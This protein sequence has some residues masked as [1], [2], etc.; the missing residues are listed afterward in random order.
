MSAYTT[1]NP[2]TQPKF[3]I[4]SLSLGTNTHHDIP[5]KVRVTSNLGYDGI[6]IF[7]PDFEAFVDEVKRGKH[8]ELFT[9]PISSCS[10]I[11]LDLAC[12]T[13][14]S[15]LCNSFGL[16]IPLFQPLRNFE[17]F[18]SQKEI[19]VGLAEAER[20]LR[21]M[22][23]MKCDLLLVCSNHLPGPCPISEDYTVDMYNDKQVNAFRQLGALAENYGVRIGY[24]PLS[25]GTV[26]DNWMQVW[27]I[28]KRVDR[29]NVGILL[30]SFN[31]LGNQYADP[32][33]ASTIRRGQ[34]LAAMLSNLEEMT[35]TI[36][37]EKIFF[38]QIADA[39]RPAGICL[40][41]INMPRRMKWSRACRVF[42]CE[43]PDS[44]S[45]KET[46]S[47]PENPPSGYLGFLPVTQ[48]TSL[49]HRMGYRGWWSLEVFNSSLQESDN[50]CP[51]RHGR[52]GI[53]GLHALWDVVQT[54]TDDKLSRDLE[55]FFDT[56]RR[57]TP[58]P[59][60]LTPPLS[61]G[62]ISDASELSSPLSDSEFE[63]EL[64]EALHRVAICDRS[65]D[66]N[67]GVDEL[68]VKHD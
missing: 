25:W 47:H 50:G 44:S 22:P 1:V 7:I 61:S 62:S 16:E 33:Q 5:T 24:E 46:I 8:T 65:T 20:W 27:N 57:A 68:K 40:D 21:I 26:I 15:N 19:D 56:G 66:N 35:M 3:A 4:A 23:A 9:E 34:T 18:H 41:D 45:A 2:Y 13:A 55:A 36:P 32:G 58:S 67:S 12:A 14:I 59:T 53:D 63:M 11:E 43:P 38:Y 31:T 54:L 60:M 52:R 51:E 48:M 37:R 30:D 17:N 64:P 6:E 10:S 28:V 49:L 42:P 39:V 29:K